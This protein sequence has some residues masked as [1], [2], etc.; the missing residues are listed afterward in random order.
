MLDPARLCTIGIP[1]TSRIAASIAAVVVAV[2]GFA[3][4]ATVGQGLLP[5]IMDGNG[6]T[7]VQ[8]YVI[9]ATLALC[10]LALAV[11][12]RR[13]PRTVLDLWLMVVMCAWLFDIALAA[14]LNAGR[15]DLGFYAGRIY[16]FVAAT[17][18]LVVLQPLLENAV[19]HG[20][21]PHARAGR[22][23]VNAQRDGETLR[24]E[25]R[26]NGGGLANGK[27]VPRGRQPSRLPYSS[28]WDVPGKHDTPHRLLRPPDLAPPAL[29]FR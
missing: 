25:V 29:S 28:R 18:V 21:E 20:I 3:A 4:L 9:S 17:F 16:G 7:P 5:A 13:R 2:I 23:E 27:P 14:M 12:W 19:R 8:T 22:I 11:L 6:Y 24:L 10:V 15:F 1:A 26:D